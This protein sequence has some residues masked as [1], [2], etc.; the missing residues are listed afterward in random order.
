MYSIT[1][2]VSKGS[3]TIVAS[4]IQ[5][6]CS[7]SATNQDILTATYMDHTPIISS[8]A[9]PFITTLNVPHHLTKLPDVVKIMKIKVNSQKSSLGTFILRQDNCSN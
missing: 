4:T 6:I 1:A 7:A 2:G 3:S 5:Y 8:A 9:S